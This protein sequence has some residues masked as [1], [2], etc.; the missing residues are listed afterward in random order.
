M[1][2]EIFLYMLNSY[3]SYLYVHTRIFAWVELIFGHPH[4]S[5]NKFSPD[6]INLGPGTDDLSCSMR[7]TIFKLLLEN[8]VIWRSLVCASSDQRICIV[9]VIWNVHFWPLD[10]S[11]MYMPWISKSHDILIISSLEIIDHI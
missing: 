10:A 4:N 11:V 3:I 9:H 5:P 6:W 8:L 2:K 1:Q 7:S